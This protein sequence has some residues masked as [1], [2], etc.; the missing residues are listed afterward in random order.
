[1]SRSRD[2]L[3]NVVERRKRILGENHFHTKDSM[4]KLDSIEINI[5]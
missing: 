4:N 3:E 5:R 1:L 2:I